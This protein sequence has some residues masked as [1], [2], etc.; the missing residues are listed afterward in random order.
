[1]NK[2]RHEAWATRQTNTG[3]QFQIVPA[4]LFV[5]AKLRFAKKIYRSGAYGPP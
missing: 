5:L 1:M 2:K 3:R 4:N